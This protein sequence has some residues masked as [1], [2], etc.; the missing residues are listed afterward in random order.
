ML[1]PAVHDG[2]SRSAPALLTFFALAFAWS[3]AC[4]LLAPAVKVDAPVGA[5]ALSL[6][7]GFGPSLTAVV[8]VAYSS[9]KSNFKSKSTL[10]GETMAQTVKRLRLHRA[11]AQVAAGA[12]S[13]RRVSAA[14]GF[15][16]EQA[17]P[18][19]FKAVCGLVPDR[20]RDEGGHQRFEVGV[21]GVANDRTKV[22]SAAFDVVEVVLE[23]TAADGVEHRGAYLSIGRAFDQLFARVAALGLGRPGM[24]MLALFHDEPG[25][26]KTAALRSTAVVVGCAPATP[27]SVLMPLM[28]DGGVF[29][30]LAHTGPYASM[31]A[32]Y[33]WLSSHWLAA[34]GRHVSA[35]PVIEEYLNC[36]QQTA[37]NDLRTYLQVPL[38][39]IETLAS[40]NARLTK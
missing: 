4:W 22:F 32:V 27:G 23:P 17:F 14:A 2:E 38:Q 33:R 6:V 3:W 31:P 16:N 25:S 13:M 5:T 37:P 34:S 36:P 30:R 39:P 7:G 40:D 15:K 21:N 19:A 11:A 35:S 12:S 20:F 10:A 18:R 24:R 8:M 28:I 1:E 29:A 26:V 9:G